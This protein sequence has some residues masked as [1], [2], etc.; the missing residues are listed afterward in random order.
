MQGIRIFL[1]AL[2]LALLALAMSA[3]SAAAAI[4]RK[5][6]P[7]SPEQASNPKADPQDIILPMQCQFTAFNI[8]TECICYPA[9][10][11]SSFY[12]I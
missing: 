5:D 1:S 8:F 11:L 2:T 4:A 10:D 3:A 7:V 9:A 12:L 6:A